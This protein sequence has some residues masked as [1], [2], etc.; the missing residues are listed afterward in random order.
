MNFGY[1]AEQE[2]LRR[3]VRAFV[4]KYV[5]PKSSPRWKDTMR[6]CLGDRP[7]LLHTGNRALSPI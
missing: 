7:R 4:E 2:A 3:E 5:T 1:S 6:G